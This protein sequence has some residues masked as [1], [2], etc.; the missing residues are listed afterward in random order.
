MLFLSILFM[1]SSFEMFGRLYDRVFA[2]A[3]KEKEWK[4]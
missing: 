4:T 3:M 2:G 1:E